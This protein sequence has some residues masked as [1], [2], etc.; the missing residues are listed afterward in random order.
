MAKVHVTTE[1]E[2]QKATNGAGSIADPKFS[3]D[4][5]PYLSRLGKMQEEAGAKLA[6]D[7]AR[8]QDVHSLTALADAFDLGFKVALQEAARNPSLLDPFKWQPPQAG[9]HDGT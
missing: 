7:V 3:Q 8:A 5:L 9:G 4:V 6:A 2:S 1:A